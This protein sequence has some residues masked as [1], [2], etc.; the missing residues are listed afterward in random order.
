[1]AFRAIVG[2]DGA[3]E[4]NIVLYP[5][6][7]GRL[8]TCTFLWDTMCVPPDSTFPAGVAGG[9]IRDEQEETANELAT[10]NA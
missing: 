4:T 9:V 1:M 3:A 10:P 6:G 5:R 7:W 8:T 2:A